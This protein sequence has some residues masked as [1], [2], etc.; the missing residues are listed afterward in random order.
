LPKA[1]SW[2]RRRD[3]KNKQLQAELDA[4]R[5]GPYDANV[6][7]LRRNSRNCAPSCACGPTPG[8]ERQTVY[9]FKQ[10]CTAEVQQSP[11]EVQELRVKLQSAQ[12]EI[13]KLR[14][15]VKQFRR[16]MER[17]TA[18]LRQRRIETHVLTP[19]EKTASPPAPKRLTTYVTG[20]ASGPP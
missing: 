18:E 5:N 8:N 11:R 3:D 2:R 1:A 17:Q 13:A 15:L 12:D 19:P 14:K 16:T 7:Q 20:L 10:P 9:G 4:L 6:Q